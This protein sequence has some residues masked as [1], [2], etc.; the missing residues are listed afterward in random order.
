MKNLHKYNTKLHVFRSH[1]ERTFDNEAWRAGLVSEKNAVAYD[2]ERFPEYIFWSACGK[3]IDMRDINDARLNTEDGQY[4]PS[5]CA[6]CERHLKI[7]GNEHREW[8]EP[9]EVHSV[10]VDVEFPWGVHWHTL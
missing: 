9:L 3:F 6:Y 8:V 4:G 1:F 10:V 7:S 5:R 2:G